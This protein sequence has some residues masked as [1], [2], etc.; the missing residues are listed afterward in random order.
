MTQVICK[1]RYVQNVSSTYRYRITKIFKNEENVTTPNFVFVPMNLFQI[2]SPFIEYIVEMISYNAIEDLTTCE[3]IPDD[4]LTDVM[5]NKLYDDYSDQINILTILGNMKKRIKSN[6]PISMRNKNVNRACL[7]NS[8]AYE[9]LGFSLEFDLNKVNN[10]DREYTFN[11][12]GKE[13]IETTMKSKGS[14]IKWKI[15]QVL[16]INNV[17]FDQYSIEREKKTNKDMKRCAIFVEE[18]EIN[19]FLYRWES[20]KYILYQNDRL[21]EKYITDLNLTNNIEERNLQ[22]F[23]CK[24]IYNNYI[25]KNKLNLSLY[26]NK[27]II[28]LLSKTQARF[29]NNML[30]INPFSM[31]LPCYRNF[32]F[33]NTI[34]ISTLYKFNMI[35]YDKIYNKMKFSEYFYDEENNNFV[36]DLVTMKL[37]IDDEEDKDLIKEYNKMIKKNSKQYKGQLMNII[38]NIYYKLHNIMLSNGKNKFDNVIQNNKYNNLY[39]LC[40]EYL[41]KHDVLC[42]SSDSKRLK[43]SY[44]FTYMMYYEYQLAEIMI[45]FINVVEKQIKYIYHDDM[46]YCIHKLS[47]TIYIDKQNEHN[48]LTI[49]RTEMLQEYLRKNK[50]ISAISFNKLIYGKLKSEYVSN[51]K[52]IVFIDSEYFGHLEL[53]KSLHKIKTMFFNVESI[54]FVGCKN[55]YK[56]YQYFGTGNFFDELD[57]I[58]RDPSIENVKIETEDYR[59]L[60]KNNNNNNNNNNEEEE[61]EDM[62]LMNVNK[63]KRKIQKMLMSGGEGIEKFQYIIGNEKIFKEMMSH[64]ISK[65]NKDPHKF[66]IFLTGKMKENSILSLLKQ[67]NIQNLLNVYSN[68]IRELHKNQVIYLRDTNEKLTVKSLFFDYNKR[69]DKPLK[70][71]DNEKKFYSRNDY[72]KIETKS[73]TYRK[74]GTIFTSKHI[75]TN[76]LLIPI[77]KY[78]GLS[79]TNTVVFIDENTTFLDIYNAFVYT[80][81]K[82]FIVHTSLKQEPADRIMK[83]ILKNKKSRNNNCN[84]INFLKN[85]Y[86]R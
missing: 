29:L 46:D 82:M 38:L 22:Y 7:E 3:N 15:K 12:Y 11:N 2:N 51:I 47:Q 26:L 76:G 10:C 53:Y 49:T 24:M 73:E 33:S 35:Y 27:S 39:R 81:Q 72:V 25:D 34:E 41:I 71:V 62:Y 32:L 1:I 65:M 17:F 40:I 54:V 9:N 21:N 64:N 84:F 80:R 23:L 70:I 4:R 69:T 45:F 44:S 56:D 58:I 78:Q 79:F 16:S 75:V 74:S 5:K 86:Q 28:D 52:Q 59:Y 37:L 30:N 85:F 83:I 50:K 43:P 42:E 66:Q 61:E 55:K 18:D 60:F 63:H 13:G 36:S 19:T 20:N 31:L 67:R 14:N 8:N 77:K 6:K 57:C 48:I 68:S